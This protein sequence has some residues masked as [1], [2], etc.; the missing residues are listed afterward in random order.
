MRVATGIGLLVAILVAGVVLRTSIFSSSA[1][2]LVP[3]SVAKVADSGS[4]A[5]SGT[6]PVQ[7]QLHSDV[8]LRFHIR[9]GFRRFGVEPVLYL[10]GI[11]AWRIVPP[12]GADNPHHDDAGNCAV[13]EMVPFVMH[14]Q[15]SSRTYIQLMGEKCMTLLHVVPM[16]RGSD[17]LTLRVYSRKILKPDGALIGKAASVSDSVASRLPLSC[18]LERCRLPVPA[19][20]AR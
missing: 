14:E 17:T 1:S 20:C 5:V 11:K 3:L 16:V 10:Q 12:V 18:R 9:H 15:T 6:V 19:A 13:T 7:E 8:W 2:I 4:V